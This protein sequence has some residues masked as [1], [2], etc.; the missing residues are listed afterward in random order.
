[1]AK[2]LTCRVMRVLPCEAVLHVFC[3]WIA[4]KER[5]R[6]PS[7]SVRHDAWKEWP[8]LVRRGWMHARDV[9]LGH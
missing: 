3:Y 4:G 1:M 2:M 7:E 8:E 6:K 5:S 9:L